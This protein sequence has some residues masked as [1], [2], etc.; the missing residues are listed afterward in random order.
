M[1]SVTTLRDALATRCGTI[2][3]LRTSSYVPDAPRPPVAIVMPQR[4]VYDLNARRGADR[5]YFTIIVMVARADDR[6]AQANLDPY[7]VGAS[8]IKA[9]VEGD[10]TLGGA[11]D[12]CRVVEM[13][14]YGM[15]PVGDTIY[16][17]AYFTVEVVA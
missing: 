12:T 9:A 3:G 5:F 11:A 2:T 17:G 16:L 4:V 6:A 14:D 13:R 8:S 10:R 7:I 1:A 15:I